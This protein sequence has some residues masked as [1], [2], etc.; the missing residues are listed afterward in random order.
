MRWLFAYRV[1]LKLICSICWLAARVCADHALRMTGFVF[2][3]MIANV[4]VCLTSSLSLAALNSNI[5]PYISDTL[6]LWSI[7]KLV[8]RSKMYADTMGRQKLWDACGCNG[9]LLS[10][11]NFRLSA[12]IYWDVRS[13]WYQTNVPSHRCV[14][15]VK[16][17]YEYTQLDTKNVLT[18]VPGCPAPSP[19]T[20]LT[21]WSSR[22]RHASVTTLFVWL[23]LSTV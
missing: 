1:I 4:R 7:S 18:V 23:P 5:F 3:I 20:R 19:A 17:S 10:F 9:T 2:S 21:H 12:D 14:L 13:L 15:D 22:R 11:H 6:G 8:Q 16:P